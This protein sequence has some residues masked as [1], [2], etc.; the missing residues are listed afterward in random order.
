M[1]GYD[2]NMLKFVNEAT[3]IP[4]SNR[5]VKINYQHKISSMKKLFTLFIG[6][7]IASMSM[8][9]ANLPDTDTFYLVGTMT[10]WQCPMP[11]ESAENWQYKLTDPDGDGVYTGRFEF[12]K[13]NF[14]EFKILS[15][16][17]DWIPPFFGCYS[18]VDIYTEAIPIYMWDYSDAWNVSVS[19]W[20]GGEVEISF[21]ISSYTTSDNTLEYHYILEMTG[22]NQP[23]LPDYEKIYLIGDFNDWR[24]PL[25][26]D[27]NGAIKFSDDYKF[28]YGIYYTL[29]NVKFNPGNL[30]LGICK[31]N[32][33]TGNPEFVKVKFDCPFTLYS[34]LDPDGEKRLPYMLEDGNWEATADPKNFAFSI[35]DWKG[36]TMT[37]R[38]S[39]YFDNSVSFDVD[40]IDTPVTELPETIY[41][42]SN[43]DNEVEKTSLSMPERSYQSWEFKECHKASFIISTE[44]SMNPSTEDCWGIPKSLKE[45]GLD[46][47][48]RS[49]RVPFIKGGEPIE[50]EFP[51]YGSISVYYDLSRSFA[52]IEINYIDSSIDTDKIYICGYVM[53]P[54]GEWNNFLSPSKSNQEIYDE[55]FR[56][57]ETESGIFEGSYY[58]ANSST[59]G[60][61]E[62]LPQFRFFTDLL[63]WS[64]V[65]SLGS[66]VP[67]FYCTPVDLSSGYAKCNIVK[68]GLGNWGPTIDMEWKPAWIHVKVDTK[69]GMLYLQIVDSGV[70]NVEATEI[71]EESWYTLQGVK[72]STPKSGIYIH[73][74]NGKSRK[75]LVR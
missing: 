1:F 69:Q 33:E 24:L 17:G 9:G 53:S 27:A 28:M 46:K 70:D 72:V 66:A 18:E 5:F 71:Y 31:L 37:F 23:V 21:S 20:N 50:F 14:P 42:I 75:E 65:A 60:Y 7:L 68:N 4:F 61:P 30:N 51:E 13:D 34:Y 40:A 26:S 16:P 55:H 59:M 22:A 48:N 64:P 39:S 19:N 62:N 38:V 32:P 8:Y 54:E 10:D 3:N 67:D 35:N 43:T 58:F 36:G 49:I 73:V 11:G 44:D 6:S 74:I 47:N 25:A 2:K 52:S 63:G 56:L 15:T 41:V 12:E 45:Y 29:H 57:T